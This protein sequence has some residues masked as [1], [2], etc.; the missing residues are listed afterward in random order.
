M[1]VNLVARASIVIDAPLARVWDGLV[2]PQAIKQY[3]FG[4]TVVSQWTVGSAIVWKGEWKGQTYED[5]GV[6]LALEPNRRLQYS[7]FSPL[8]G[9]P[10]VPGNYHTVTFELAQGGGRTRV[11]LTQDHNA[12]AEARDHSEQNW[13]VVLEGL[14]RLLEK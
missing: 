4:T 7:H 9:L 14:K 10:D 6:I 8:S 12:T 11:S 3:L 13:R 2:D 5:K 1:A